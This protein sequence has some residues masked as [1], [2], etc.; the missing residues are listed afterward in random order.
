VLI[1]ADG[2]IVFY[3]VGAGG[4]KALRENLAKLGLESETAK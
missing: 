4:E 3:H 1:D 2:K